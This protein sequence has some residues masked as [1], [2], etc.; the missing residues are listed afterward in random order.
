MPQL[1][2]SDLV[3]IKYNNA[4]VRIHG[5]VD[6]QNLKSATETFLKKAEAQKKR[7]VNK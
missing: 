6:M 2:G 3:E 7:K 1:K 5:T 4:T